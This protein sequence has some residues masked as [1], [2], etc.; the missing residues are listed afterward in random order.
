MILVV[1]MGKS[2][3]ETARYLKN[4]QIPFHA[5]DEKKP[6]SAVIDAIGPGDFRYFNERPSVEDYEFLVLSPGI[7][8]THPLVIAAREKKVPTLSEIEFA[9]RQT[10]GRI[11]AVT[12]SN[13]KSTTASLIH[14]LLAEN[15]LNTSLCGNIGV[16]FIS[17]LT[18]DPQH[19]YVVEVSSF[20]MEH[21]R[22]FC[23]EVGLLLNIAPDHLDRHGSMEAYTAAKLIMFARQE[24]GHLAITHPDFLGQL[25]GKGEKITVPGPSVEL[26]RGII[27]AGCDFEIPNSCLPLL[28]AHNRMNAL[29]A[30]MAVQYFGL[31]AEAAARVLPDFKGLE[32]RMEKVGIYKDV[33]WINDSKATNVHATQAA[34]YSIEQDYVLVLGGCDKG[35][36]FDSLNF[37]N[38]APRAIV[39]YGEMAPLIMNDLHQWNP[40]HIHE[41]DEACLKAHQLAQ[42]GDALLMSPA[43]ASFDQFSNFMARGHAFKDL[44]GKL[45]GAS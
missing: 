34:V 37:Q 24:A 43:C 39:A 11:V 17:C 16:P 4:H 12:G 2:G 26:A 21:V 19:I 1:G 45:A 14:H 25:P 10:N 8:L 28:G 13:G 36:R 35:E 6:A 23:P 40:V 20:Q 7:P 33:L 18:N 27:R 41:F 30:C 9:F 44:F 5:F 22:D 42:P 38:R 29:F 32:H 3:M 31:T 15:G